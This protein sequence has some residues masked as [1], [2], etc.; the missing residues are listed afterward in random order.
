[1][2]P[3]LYGWPDQDVKALIQQYVKGGRMRIPVALVTAA[4]MIAALADSRG[5][6]PRS[7][8]ID[9]C[10]Q[11]A[12]RWSGRPGVRVSAETRNVSSGKGAVRVSFT[13]GPASKRLWLFFWRNLSPPLD[14]SGY[15][16]VEFRVRYEGPKTG[17]L[18]PY[19][20]YRATPAY[21]RA[22]TPISD[23][24]DGAWRLCRF[25]LDNVTDR[26]AVAQLRFA[27]RPDKF[28]T[29]AQA[30]FVFDDVRAVRQ[31]RP[32]R[33]RITRFPWP[34]K[35]RPAPEGL[36]LYPVIPFEHIYPDTDPTDRPPLGRLS[37]TACRGE[38][39]FLTFAARTKRPVNDLR[40]TAMD[41]RGPGGQVIPS[42]VVDVRVV[43]VW[44][45]SS[46]GQIR[47]GRGVP[48]R[49][50]PELLVYDD[51]LGFQDGFVKVDGKRTAYRPPPPVKP[52]LRTDLAA[53]L[54]KQFW[55]TVT[56][57]ANTAPGSYRG[58]LKLRGRGASD[59][60][61]PLEIEVL[62]WAL[63]RPSKLY[64]TYDWYVSENPKS[65]IYKS[66]QR[67]VAELRAMQ[68]AGMDTIAL[69]VQREKDVRLILRRMKTAGM[70]GPFV[71]LGYFNATPEQ[72][73]EARRTAEEYGI[74][75]CFYGKDEPNNPMKIRVHL[76]RV[77]SAVAGGG[78]T[79]AAIT[80]P[81]VLRLKDPKSEP[82]ALSAGPVMPLHWANVAV[83]H[84]YAQYLRLRA[85]GRMGRLAPR[86]TIYW[87]Y[88]VEVPTM[89]RFLAGFHVWAAGMDGAFPNVFMS[90]LPASPYNDGDRRPP[91]RRGRVARPSCTVYPTQAEPIPTLQWESWR[92]GITDS[93]Y[94]TLLTREITRARRT[95]RAKVADRAEAALNHA[96]APFGQV[97]AAEGKTAVRLL[98]A[99]ACLYVEPLLMQDART[100]VVAI[101][102]TLVE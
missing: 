12:R 54:T 72:I 66:E 13:G 46:P 23:L 52:P 36:T 47:L 14:L 51:A 31:P 40:I 7:L 98:D 56:V 83:E 10:E 53:G 17:Y 44:R 33:S 64:G 19:L 43:K 91:D 42:R 8:Q 2:L 50:I 57:A 81:Y 93:R 94:V 27:V 88:Y 74:P 28:P 96:L 15:T 55:V 48:A 73:A 90:Y 67:H 39:P 34:L 58:A 61:L 21:G 80:V 82:Y 11:V 79:M 18:D 100:R 68:E 102:R 89:N 97:P 78:R 92:A 69:W 41:L 37:V 85:A 25:P 29:G 3:S 59:T 9:D 30:A 26:K 70:R 32:D 49:D 86:Q 84:T 75:V 1:M 95:G 101:L 71:T 77:R 65:Y 20:G 4:L 76:A 63:P 16:H 87:Q 45:Q 62:P 24:G 60:A 5:A 35:R 6:G 38:R 22:M 99:R